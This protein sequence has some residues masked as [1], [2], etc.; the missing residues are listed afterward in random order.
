MEDAK[1]T[2]ETKQEP[3]YPQERYPSVVDTDDLTFELGR[4]TIA[5]LNYEKLIANLLKR[6]K[7]AEAS[8]MQ[9]RSLLAAA[10]QSKASNKL[11][12]ENNRKLDAEIVALRRKIETI[13]AERKSREDTLNMSIDSLKA[14]IAE[15]KQA[16]RNA[17]SEFEAK[18]AELKRKHEEELHKAE[19]K[20]G[21]RKQERP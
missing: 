9:A 12:E 5:R 15:L 2:P 17:A 21:R 1:I 7:D 14:E 10:E 4:S 19:E 6:A 20:K 3:L 16:A 13:T 8:I 11:Y 18:Q